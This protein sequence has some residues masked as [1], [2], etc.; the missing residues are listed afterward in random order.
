MLDAFVA[1]LPG[2]GACSWL[3][4]TAANGALA[5]GLLI[6]FARNLRP[7]PDLASFD[8]PRWLGLAVAATAL[9]G[10]AAPG[11]A[12][13]VGENLCLILAMPYFF[14]GLAL[15]HAAA[16]RSGARAGHFM[17][18]YL[19]LALIIVIMSWVVI[20]GVAALGLIDQLVG[21]RQRLM[22]PKDGPDGNWE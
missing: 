8:L 15:A 12:G 20:F 17:L 22:R 9:L 18:L 11:T 13:F 19:F 2:L 4:V 16:R 21:L 1:V 5:Q 14:G 10:V 6:R 7:S 3:L